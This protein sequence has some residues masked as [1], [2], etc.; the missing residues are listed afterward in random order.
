M[1]VNL[2]FG[3]EDVGD[4]AIITR[5][6]TG[7]S[8]DW[9]DP[10]L[11]LD[12]VGVDFGSGEMHLYS[13]ATGRAWRVPASSA[14]QEILSLEA[15]TLLICE[16]AHLA[17]PRTKASLAQPFT[18]NELLRLYSEAKAGGITIKLFP[19]YHSG[20]RAR[21]WVAFNIPEV[22]SAEK[23]DAAD[24]RALAIYVSACNGIS[25]ANPPE[26]FGMDPK[27][28]YGRAVAKYSSVAL[29]AERTDGY[30]GRFFPHIVELGREIERKGGSRLG[31]LN[32]V[33]IASLVATEIDGSP[34]LFV[35]NDRVPGYE[36]WRRYVA[37]MTP[38]HHRGGIAR[39]NIMRHSFRP[40][41]RKFG[42]RNGVA[43]GAG[44]KMIPFG[45]HSPQ[46]AEIKTRAMRSFRGSMKACYRVAVDV[47][48]RRGFGTIDPLE[49]PW[50]DENA[51]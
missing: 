30:K 6:S 46:Q 40:F 47:A 29:N 8:R 12:V 41:L 7:G 50:G 20:T 3:W 39:S 19:H 31:W 32:C 23:T 22:E 25:L 9:C 33:S 14:R 24:A 34:M 37:R 35:R 45:E 43:M 48:V 38:W 26:S 17:T 15:G 18:A 49:T 4:R 21:P 5:D 44:A 28:Q 42:Q 51:R 1:A 10:A 2:T 36:T 11:F 27:R 13:V 16:S